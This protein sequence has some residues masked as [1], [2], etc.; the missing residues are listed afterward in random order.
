MLRKLLFMTLAVLLLSGTAV[1][2]ENDTQKHPSCPMCGMDRAQ[3]SHSRMLIEYDDGTSFGAC[4][5]HCAAV[6]LATKL[7]KTPTAILVGDYYSQKLVDA[8]K[9]VWVIGGSRSGVMTKRPKWAFGKKADAE[10][11]ISENG[12]AVI[13]FDK[14]IKSAYEDMYLDTKMIREKR[15]MMKMKKMQ[16]K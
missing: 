7:D 3:F 15:K 8:E 13:D 16:V 6:E 1:F 12:G 10:K 14:A 9:A 2:A 5:L 4:S 11:F